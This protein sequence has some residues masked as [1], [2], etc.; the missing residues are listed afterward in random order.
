M[1][2]RNQGLLDNLFYIRITWFEDKTTALL[3]RSLICL[4]FHFVPFDLA[5]RLRNR[6]M[7]DKAAVTNKYDAWNLADLDCL[8]T[9]IIDLACLIVNP[10]A[11]GK[12]AYTLGATFKK[13]RYEDLRAKHIF[14]LDVPCS[15]IVRELDEQSTNHWETAVGAILGLRIDIRHKTILEFSGL[16]ESV[17]EILADEPRLGWGRTMGAAVRR[18]EAERK[19]TTIDILG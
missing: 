3:S 18:E 6:D 13:R 4:Q 10:F 17:G 12:V 19:P 11:S 15:W 9:T 5:C 8:I 7:G 16:A 2:M 1:L 14:V